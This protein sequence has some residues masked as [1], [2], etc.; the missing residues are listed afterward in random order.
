MSVVAASLFVFYFLQNQS[1]VYHSQKPEPI[2]LQ[3]PLGTYIVTYSGD[4]GFV[5]KVNRLDK[6]FTWFNYVLKPNNEGQI[7]ISYKSSVLDYAIQNRIKKL[8]IPP[9]EFF[10]PQLLILD[11][12]S[13]MTSTTTETSTN[14]YTYDVKFVDAYETLVTYKIRSGPDMKN[15]RV[16]IPEVCFPPLLLTIGSTPYQGIL[17]TLP[18]A[19]E[20]IK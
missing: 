7:Q 1:Y 9:H 2:T 13:G 20:E 16:I 17:P 3:C 5:A 10:K 12:E 8:N 11:E 15:Y 6:N 18:P 4:Q 14:I 19:G